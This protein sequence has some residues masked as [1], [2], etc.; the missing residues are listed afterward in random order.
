MENIDEQIETA[1]HSTELIIVFL[2]LFFTLRY[3]EIQAD[4]DAKVPEGD[5][6]KK[7]HKRKL[8]VSMRAKCLP[9]V[10]VNSV[11]TYLYMPLLVK[12]L[13]NSKLSLWDFDFTRTSFFL[14]AAAVMYFCYWSWSLTVL[15]LQRIIQC[16][17]RR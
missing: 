2:T 10:L 1:F 7:N 11:V 3:P 8:I 13:R 15:L 6:A 5:V 17:V 9:F 14:I 16:N 12:V 4:V